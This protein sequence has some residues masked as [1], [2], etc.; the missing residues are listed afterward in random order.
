MMCVCVCYTVPLGQLEGSKGE[1]LKINVNQSGYY[2]V[3]YP[4]I[5]W[6]MNTQAVASADSPLSQSDVAGLLD[7]SYAL[8]QIE[9]AINISVWLEL[10]RCDSFRARLSVSCLDEELSSQRHLCAYLPWSAVAHA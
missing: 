2:R 8:H 7:D 10:V 1:F 6:Q 4:D 3:Q 5:M 9:G